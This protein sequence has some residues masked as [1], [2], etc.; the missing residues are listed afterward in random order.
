MA[1]ALYLTLIKNLQSSLREPRSP[2]QLQFCP[3]IL[4]R[5]EGFEHIAIYGEQNAR[6]YELNAILYRAGDGVA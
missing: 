3:D 1:W 5:R 2:T 4:E 6:E